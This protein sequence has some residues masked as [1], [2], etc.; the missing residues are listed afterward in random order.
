[1]GRAFI[2][3]FASAWLACGAQAQTVTGFVFEDVDR[4]GVRDVGEPPIEGLAVTIYGNNGADDTTVTTAAD[5]SFTFTVTTGRRYVLDLD[6]GG[7]LRL[8]FQDPGADPDPIPDWPQGRRRPGELD[9]LASNLRAS[10]TAAP[11]L[12]VA[13]GDSIAYGFN[14]CDSPGGANDYVTP[15]TARLD[16][17]NEA[18]LSKLAVLGHETRDLLDPAGAGT[19]FDAIAAGAQLVTIS[20]GGND[21]LADDGDTA[22][23]AANLVNA[24]RNLQEI[25]STLVTELPDCDVVLNTVYDNEGGDDA[26]HNTWGPIWNQALRDVAWGQRR[27]VGIAEVWPDYE[28]LD[29]ATGTKLGEDGL[30]CW[31]FGLDAIHPTR[32]GYDLHE[33]KLW[34]GVGGL[35]VV[36]GTSRRDFGFLRRMESRFPTRA[37]DVGGGASQEADAF[38]EDGSG[39][40]VPGGD[41]ELQLLGFDATPRGL[42]SQ[43]VVNVRYRTR[44]AP[45]DDV[46]RF[47]ASVDG[48]F[49][50]PG[51]DAASWNT[52]VPIVGG[53]GNG[54]PVLAF[55][56]QPEWREVSALVTKGSAGDGAPTLAWHDLATLAVRVKGEAVGSADPFDLEWDVASIDL[57]GVPPYRLLLRGRPVIG[58]TIQF[59][60]TGP[61]GA[62]DLIFISAGTGHVPVPPWGVLELDLATFALI[63]SGVVDATGAHSF[64]ADLPDDASLVGVTVHVQSLIVESWLPPAGALTNLASLTFE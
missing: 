41:Q 37:L 4:D 11:L 1:V 64:T 34:Q 8:S 10:S 53:A 38:A 3:A 51:G 26:F 49:V 63:G 48:S 54:V 58:Q 43:V 56:D 45:G 14:L 55:S 7:G 21:F 18:L 12:H 52:I 50:A 27:R 28:H 46:Y 2:G 23:T 47:E 60:A 42:L 40:L 57:Y 20:I 30:I 44:S 25:L 29:P 36:S 59:D 22:R 35:N 24:R 13:L 19:I 31:F 9:R 17:V 61:E 16:A 33:E 15:F 62:A 6:P 5:G 39:A 32:R